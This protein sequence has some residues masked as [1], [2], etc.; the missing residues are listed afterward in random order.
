M[1]PYASRRGRGDRSSHPRRRCRSIKSARRPCSF[2]QMLTT[3]LSSKAHGRRELPC[4]IV[5]STHRIAR[6][7]GVGRAGLASAR[8]LRCKHS[9]DL[10][11]RSPRQVVAVSR[12]GVALTPPI[13]RGSSQIR[14]LVEPT[15]RARRGS[16]SPAQKRATSGY[17]RRRVDWL[18]SIRVRKARGPRFASTN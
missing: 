18:A 7:K 11:C 16:P 10:E 12:A 6:T 5:A 4:V 1:S 8:L 14:A 2:P 9:P 17:R 15:W 13:A 3:V